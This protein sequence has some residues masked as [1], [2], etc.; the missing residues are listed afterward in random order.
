MQWV[1][2]EI[3]ERNRTNVVALELGDRGWVRLF[4]EETIAGP[5][6]YH[7][8]HGSEYRIGLFVEDIATGEDL[9]L[10]DDEVRTLEAAL[11]EGGGGVA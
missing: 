5:T 4:I 8:E 1:R 9:D 6:S 11:D 2:E 3:E 7:P 10:T